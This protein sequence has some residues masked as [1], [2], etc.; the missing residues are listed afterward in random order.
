MKKLDIQITKAALQSFSVTIDDEMPK[1][2]ATIALLTEGGKTITT[3]TIS[4]KSWNEQDKF[5]LPIAAMPHLGAV[6]RILEEVVTKHCND[7]QVALTAGATAFDDAP[8]DLSSI[9]F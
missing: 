9:P 5:D 1:V 8:I 2:S 3:Y 6:A 7:S 4:N